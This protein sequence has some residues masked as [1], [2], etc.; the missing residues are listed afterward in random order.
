VID[1]DSRM[2][3]GRAVTKTE[4]QAALLLMRMLK[5][6]HP[7]APPA[8]ATDAMGGYAE[9]IV[10]TWGQVPAYSGSGRPPTR[11]QPCAGWKYLQVQKIRSGSR[12]L[13]VR[14]EVIFGDPQEVVETLG[15]HTAYI[16]R[17]QLTSRQM[18]GRIVRKTL[19]FS[20]ALRCLKAAC[21]WEDAVYNWTRQHQSLRLP[22]NA[23]DGRWVERS[24]AMAAGLTDHVWSLREL[25]T[26]VVRPTAHQ[27]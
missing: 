5:Q 27:R 22:S 24:P 8:I 23:E 19:S 1:I 4:P 17:S 26:T 15:K 7:E 11:K 20:K 12:L 10:E 25:L 14:T 6:A 16:E 2:R 3:L 13:D 9:A 18:N 21:A